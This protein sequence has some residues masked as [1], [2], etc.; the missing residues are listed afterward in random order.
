[1]CIHIYLQLKIPATNQNRRFPQDKRTVRSFVLALAQSLFGNV[2][3]TKTSRPRPTYFSQ[4]KMMI[5]G[6][7]KHVYSLPLQ[8]NGSLFI[9]GA[10]YMT[11]M[12]SVSRSIFS[13]WEFPAT[14]DR[15][16]DW[17][18][19]RPKSVRPINTRPHFVE[20]LSSKY[21]PVCIIYYC[22]PPPPPP[23]H[24]KDSKFRVHITVAKVS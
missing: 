2:I 10:I 18:F 7:S 11:D 17:D 19:Y 8:C 21:I 4:R 12:Y 3:T 1:M 13:D 5:L 14:F 9:S 16:A 20:R 6:I 23:N 15:Q 22:Y 24:Y